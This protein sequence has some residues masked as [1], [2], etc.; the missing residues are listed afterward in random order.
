MEQKDMEYVGFWLR[1]CASLIDTF[2]LCLITFPLRT[3]V[4]GE[5]AYLAMS[6]ILPAALFIRS[7]VARGQTPVKVVI[8]THVVDAGT[9]Q[10]ITVGKAIL[11][12]LAYSLTMIGLFIGYLW[13]D[14]DPKSRAGTITLPA[15]L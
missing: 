2:I 3:V 5:Q 11:R 14:L 15:P 6:W 4:Y 12:Y 7:L 10:R 8:G 9:G 13:V 1:L